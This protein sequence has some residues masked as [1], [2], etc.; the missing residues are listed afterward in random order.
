MGEIKSVEDLEVYKKA[1]ALF[2]DFVE[3]DIVILKESFQGRTLAGNQLRYLDSI[4]ANMEEGFERK[5]G[6]ETKHFFR[7]SRGST[8]E[9]RGRLKRF[10]R[11]LK[12][13][14]LTNV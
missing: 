6:K 8:G 3:H 4:C 7:I 9:A 11:L 1:V 10:K 5:F 2:D 12:A 13:E 14:L